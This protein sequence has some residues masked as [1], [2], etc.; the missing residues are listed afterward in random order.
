MEVCSPPIVEDILREMEV[1]DNSNEDERFEVEW[2]ARRVNTEA[3]CWCS[4]RLSTASMV[5]FFATARLSPVIFKDLYQ[6]RYFSGIIALQTLMPCNFI[7]RTWER[8]RVAWTGVKTSLHHRHFHFFPLVWRS[9][10]AQRQMFWRGGS[11]SS[12]SW[13]SWSKLSSSTALSIVMTNRYSGSQ[14]GHSWLTFSA[15]CYS[16]ATWLLHAITT[17]SSLTIDQ[18]RC[19]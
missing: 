1:H 15:S 2:F 9:T 14:C 8:A 4:T 7:E 3:V 6:R 16:T 13:G 5:R 12:S 11:S 17:V 18:A 19:V 10:N